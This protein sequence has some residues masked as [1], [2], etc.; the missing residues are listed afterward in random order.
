MLLP[1]KWVLR[2]ENPDY[3]GDEEFNFFMAVIFPD[4]DLKI[5]DYNRVVKD[6]NGSTSEEF[7][8][9]IREAGFDVE[10]K[11]SDIY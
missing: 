4:N 11:G 6:L 10:E 3:T 2:E 8:D 9:K 1:A 7:L 5:F